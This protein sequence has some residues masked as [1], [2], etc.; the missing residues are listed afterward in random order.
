FGSGVPAPK[1][2]LV[3]SKRRLRKRPRVLTLLCL[4]E[5]VLFHVLKGL[6]AEDLLSL[7]DGCGL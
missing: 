7:R 2:F 5:D 3:P 4:P 1:C 6:P